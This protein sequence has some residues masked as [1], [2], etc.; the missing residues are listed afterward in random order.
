M[1]ESIPE[2]LVDRVVVVAGYGVEEIIEFSESDVVPYDVLLS[3]EHE[4]L[5]TGELWHMLFQSSRGR[6]Q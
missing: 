6:A 3:V 5:G 1:V 4:P 2:D